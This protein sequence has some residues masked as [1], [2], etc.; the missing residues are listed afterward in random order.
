MSLAGN[1]VIVA[2]DCGTSSTKAI[3]LDDQGQ[4]IARTS[5]PLALTTPQPG[6]VEHEG[7][8]IIR[9]LEQAITQLLTMIDGSKVVAVGLSNQR[10]SL[11]LWDRAT[12]KAISPVLSWQDRRATLLARTLA[13]AGHG[14]DVR[15]ISG[16]PLDPMFSAVKATWL[17][18]R[19][20]PER[21]RSLAGEIALGTID[22]WVTWN[23]TGEHVTEPGNAS[24]TSLLSL[25]SVQW[26]PQLLELFGVPRTCLPHIGT[27]VRTDL[28]IRSGPLHGVNLAGLIGDSHAAL[29]AHAGWNA[30]TA[31]ATLGTGSSVMVSVD[32]TVDSLAL[33]RTIG[34]QMLDHEPNYALEANILSAGATL[35]WLA[36]IM[37]TTPEALAEQ[38]VEET[39]VVFVPGFDGLAAPWWDDRA[40]AI[41]SN[42]SLS[43]SMGDLARAALDSVAMQIADVVEAFTA[44]SVHLDSLVVDG[45]MTSNR[46]LVQSL[47]DACGLPM[48]IADA[49]EASALGAAHIAGLGAS[50]WTL[51][52]LAEFDRSYRTVEPAMSSD[53]RH[54]IAHRWADAVTRSRMN[55]HDRSQ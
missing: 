28:V 43:T 23:L 37:N 4:V 51:G 31:K 11:V 3:A 55:G 41:I 39:D 29:F 15:R 36:G 21:R 18:D 40:V 24:R 22:S 34:W 52:D 50:L 27:S 33:C 26:D 47:A 6:W 2:L 42:L 7:A 35:S 30:G 49:A 20:D 5:S 9:S 44:S 53:R 19:Y 12:G 48:R 32:S 14:S 8:E 10:E 38:A 45:S 17:L 46:I 1:R 25:D 13:D 54:R 16:L